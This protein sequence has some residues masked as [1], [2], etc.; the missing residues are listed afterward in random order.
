ML[1]CLDLLE[2][3]RLDDS[4]EKFLAGAQ[5]SGRAL[6]SMLA[7]V[8]DYVSVQGSAPV[9][10]LARVEPEAL[11]ADC[12]EKARPLVAEAGLALALEVADTVPKQVVLDSHR[13]ERILDNLL[14]NARKFTRSGGIGVRL[15]GD[16]S[17]IRIVVHDTGEGMAAEQQEA[18]FRPFYQVDGSTTRQVGGTGL[19]L[20]LCRSLVRA[21]GGEIEVSSEPGQGSEFV[22]TLPV[23]RRVGAPA[24][25]D[26]GPGEPSARAP[27]ALL[28]DDDS[29]NTFVLEKMLD[30][31]GFEVTKAENGQQALEQ[32]GDGPFDLV[33]LDYQM[34]VLDGP[35]T[36]LRIRELEN[37][38]G[39]RPALLVAVTGFGLEEYEASCREAGFDRFLTKPLRFARLEEIAGEWRARASKS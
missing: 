19:G 2:G 36:A 8:L 17:Q 12:V 11:V 35:A 26:E 21:M 22:V 29:S 38:S 28:A 34:P 30:R 7:D 16:E 31:L 25:S 6:F 27:R 20:A 39:W 3:T 32:F 4:Q 37:E 9:L 10:D 5:K 15:E 14:D 13:V 18:I 33:F 23:R 24:A 1:G